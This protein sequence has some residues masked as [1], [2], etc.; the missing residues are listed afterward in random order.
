MLQFRFDESKALAVLL[1]V[2]TRLGGSGRPADLHRIFKILYFADMKHLVEWG[3]PI[4]GDQYCVLPYGPGPDT[5]YER[6]KDMRDQGD[7]SLSHLFAELKRPGV[8]RF[9]LWCG[10]A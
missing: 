10:P 6:I 7:E 9:D 4:H 8:V 5:L 1:Y 2:A 3:R